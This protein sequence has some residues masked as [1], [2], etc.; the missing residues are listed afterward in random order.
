MYD[1]CGPHLRGLT[2]CALVVGTALLALA[3]GCGKGGP[4]RN[5]I[6]GTVQLDGKPLD[7]GA[8]RFSPIEGT[9]GPIVGGTIENGRYQLSKAVGPMEGRHR[10]EIKC[11]SK[12][13]PTSPHALRKAGRDGA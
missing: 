4:T 7:K 9:K 6:S 5:A 2:R 13:R 12:D 8:I 11:Q 3:V 1:I 10:V